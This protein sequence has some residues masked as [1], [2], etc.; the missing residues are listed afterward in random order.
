[1]TARGWWCLFVAGLMLTVGLLQQRPV[2]AVPGLAVVLW[3]GWEWLF[4]RLR[5]TTLLRHLRLT[6]EVVD[7]RGPL[8]TLWSG[9]EYTV[10]VTMRLDRSGWLPYL[11]A[12]DVVPFG[13]RHL[14][15]PTS[16]DGELRRDTP[17][18]K[19]SIRSLL[20]PG[21]RPVPVRLEL[22]D[23]Q[24]LFAHVAFARPG[25]PARILPGVLV[26]RD[27][28]PAD[29]S[30]AAQATAAGYPPSPAAGVGERTARP[31][32]PAGRSAADDRLEGVGPP[33]PAGDQGV[34]ERGAGPL[35]P[36]RRRV[37]VGPRRLAGAGRRRGGRIAPPLPPARPAAGD[38][39]RRHPGGV[40]G[41][42]SDR[43][44]PVRRALVPHRPAG[45][46]G[47]P[48]QSKTG[49]TCSAMPPRSAR[50]P[51][52]DPEE[53]VPV[54]YAAQEVYPDLLAAEVN[55]MPAWL[56]WLVAFPGYTRHRRGWVDR[57]H[58]RNRTLLVWGTLA[59]SAGSAGG[60][61][62]GGQP[63]LGAG[64]GARVA[65]RR[66]GARRSVAGVPDVVCV[67]LRA[68]GVGPAA[69]VARWRNGW[70]RCWR[71][72]ARRRAT[73][74]VGCRAAGWTRHWK[75]TTCSRR[76]CSSF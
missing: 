60:Q 62:G 27:G 5:V 65:R 18:T 51:R 42:R 22:T 46:D 38:R 14:D 25:R 32:R 36:L 29:R 61:S 4:F 23:L 1:M 6:R 58:R 40:D 33:R 53:L 11:R 63:R 35:H 52:A 8:A 76:T 43:T 45:A 15:G 68:G 69:A 66:R 7:I 2:L 56:T 64:L 48:P 26:Q 34:R 71:S 72:A 24:G 28:R 57:L 12:V 73:R 47:E 3:V 70:R 50:S 49:C 39:R 75:T 13:V 37:R 41:A 54:A 74:T 30:G 44:V 19:S 67:L 10:R 17:L 20:R 9:R 31:P 16:A 21:R 59:D 55:A